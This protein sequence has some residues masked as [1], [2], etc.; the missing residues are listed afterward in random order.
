MEIIYYCQDCQV[1]INHNFHKLQ[2]EIKIN[3]SH[4]AIKLIVNIIKLIKI[5]ES[6]EKI[7][8]SIHKLK[9]RK[10]RINMKKN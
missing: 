3:K 4:N 1:I 6:K 10:L 9:L 8:K 5:A 7:K 2:T